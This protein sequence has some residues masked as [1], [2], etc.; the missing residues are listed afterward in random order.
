MNRF[1]RLALCLAGALLLATPA[2]AAE[3]EVRM[4]NKGSDRQAMVFEPAFLR[5]QPGD[6]VRFKPTDKGHDVEAVAGMLPE[7][8][9]PFKSAISQGLVVTFE[10]A[11]VYGY[12]CNP[13]IGMGMVGLVQVGTDVANLDAARKVKLPP[14]AVKRM[15]ALFDQAARQATAEAKP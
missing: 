1:D 13:H 10:K 11:G 6:T 3:F 12:Q 15:A 2:G 7:G 9:T 8:V 14:F 5:V 4:L